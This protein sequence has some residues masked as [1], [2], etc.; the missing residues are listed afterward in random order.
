MKDYLLSHIDNQGLATITLNRPDIHNAFDEELIRLLSQTIGQFDNDPAIR[1]IKL[2]ANGKSFSA[3]ADLNWMQKMAQYTQKENQADAIRLA[4]LFEGL[5][6]ISK[7]TIALVQGAAIGG[8]VGLVAACDIA[9]AA[10][11]A[12]FQLSEVKLGLIPAVVSP[13]IISAI[14]TRAARRFFLTGEKFS[15]QEAL[16]LGLVHQVVPHDQL[17]AAAKHFCTNLLQNGPRAMAAAKDLVY[18][19]HNTEHTKEML[20]ETAGRIAEIRVS[21]EGREGITAFLEKRKPLWI[22]EK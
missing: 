6:R 1:V 14:G 2:V 12:V 9:I 5:T 3:G 17:A 4:H 19:H 18:R 11:N 13:Y 21:E 16:R 10:E 7:P 22:K 20:T 8:G 15:A